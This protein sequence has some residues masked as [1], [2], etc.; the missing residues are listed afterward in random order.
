MIYED[1]L[2]IFE[3]FASRACCLPQRMVAQLF[4]IKQLTSITVRI[5]EC[6]IIP[7]QDGYRTPFGFWSSFLEDTTA[8]KYDQGIIGEAVTSS[9][10]E[11][12]RVVGVPSRTDRIHRSVTIM[13]STHLDSIPSVLEIKTKPW[14]DE[15]MSWQRSSTNISGS[16]WLIK[17]CNRIEDKQWSSLWLWFRF[18]TWGRL[19]WKHWKISF[20]LIYSRWMKMNFSENTHWWNRQ[21]WNP[22][23]SSSYR[24]IRSIRI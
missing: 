24:I 9:S 17:Y 19:C 22:S 5:I 23:S 18:R 20:I 2:N 4:D 1:C 14:P 15:W 10:A 6:K 7:D 16:K 11:Q 13:N 3:E 8:R 21:Q 12:S